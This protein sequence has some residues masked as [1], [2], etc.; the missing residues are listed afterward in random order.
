VPPIT[1]T[2]GIPDPGSL[3]IDEL[4]KVSGRVL[5]REGRLALQY[6]G[7]QGFL[8]L[9]QWVAG[10]I[11]AVDGV[12]LG[13]ENVTITNGSAG[14]LANICETFL[15]E[16][17]AVI[18]EAPTFP[19]AVGAMRALGAQIVPVPLDSEGIQ[20]DVLE[21]K[22]SDLH[23]DGSGRTKLLYTIPNFHNPSGVTATESR[24][25]KVLELCR[26]H[27]VWI[28]ED[29]AYGDMRLDGEP[30]PS[31]FALADGRGVFRVGTFSKTI[32]TGLRVGWVAADQPTVDALVRQR[33]DMG[34]SPWI[35]RIV[36]EYAGSG[37]LDRHLRTV[38]D[39]YRRKRDLMLEQLARYCT[40]F[41]R[42]ETPAGGFFLWLR[43][44]ARLD[45]LTLA[46]AASQEGVAFVSG[47]PFFL[48][49]GSESERVESFIRL[50]YSFVAEEEIT[51]AI[52]RLGRAMERAASPAGTK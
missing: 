50:A 27:N 33:F 30:V 10:R 5:E 43:L 25:R 20:T 32:A 26:R 44:D 36:A 17:D 28:M 19:I 47:D 18:I 4:V 39:I 40:P 24:R 12:A 6:G 2:G 23:T 15:D 46:D 9:R 16:G 13:P 31:Y 7:A 14:A 1:L 3:P 51:E 8:D 22:L 37:L 48:A 52:A 38:L 29:D 41:A 21:K 35:Q 45:T 42:W 11:S 49:G 34:T